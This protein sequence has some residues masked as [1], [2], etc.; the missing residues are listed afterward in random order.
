[1]A[2]PISR[3]LCHSLKVCTVH[4][5][6]HHLFYY[7]W[8]IVIMFVGWKFCR[9][10]YHAGWGNLR[11]SI[12]HIQWEILAWYL[13]DLRIVCL[14]TLNCK[15]CGLKRQRLNTIKVVKIYF[16]PFESRVN[17]SNDHNLKSLF[18]INGQKPYFLVNTCWGDYVAW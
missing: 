3:A 2:S 10:I 18:V 11:S 12:T 9:C 1:M 7:F 13:R 5:S 6:Q 16:I 8:K 14:W 4:I 17:I 15:I